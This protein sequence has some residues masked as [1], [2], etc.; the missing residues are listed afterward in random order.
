MRIPDGFR[1]AYCVTSRNARLIRTGMIDNPAIAFE[2]PLRGNAA[3]RRPGLGYTTVDGL[4]S[5]L[6]MPNLKYA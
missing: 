1:P 3:I 5:L 6:F 4:S 2:E